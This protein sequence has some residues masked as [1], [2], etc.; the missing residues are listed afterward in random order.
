[1]AITLGGVTLPDLTIEQEYGWTGVEAAVDMSVGGAPI[2]WERLI[3]GRPLDLAG[4][5]D[6]GWILRSVLDSL[7][8]LA[9]VPRA[10]YTLAYE[11]ETYTA[12]FRHEEGAI[13][14]APVVP[15]PNQA[16][17]DYYRNVR[18]RLMVIG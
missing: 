9:A 16:S 4:G 14:A 13:E 6:T 17:G 11:G 7:K 5:E 8:A 2:V 15:R 10:T 18:I 12:R 1:M 3:S